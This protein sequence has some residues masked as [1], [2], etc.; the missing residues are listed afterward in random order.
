MTWNHLTLSKNSSTASIELWLVSNS[1]Y[2]QD[3][4]KKN[5]NG[6]L[7]WIL[8]GKNFKIVC[9]NKVLLVFKNVQNLVFTPKFLLSFFRLM[10]LVSHHAPFLERLFYKKNSA[11]FLVSVVNYTRS[12]SFPRMHTQFPS[13]LHDLKSFY[14]VQKQFY[15][16]NRMVVGLTFKLSTRQNKEKQKGHIF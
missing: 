8:T 15:C 12:C 13:N 2:R 6:T 5:K 7:F 14:Y 11:L 16:L 3:R 10:S 4:I 1:S 9:R